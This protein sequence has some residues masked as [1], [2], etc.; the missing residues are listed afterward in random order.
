MEISIGIVAQL[1]LSF[2]QPGFLYVRLLP[3]SVDVCILSA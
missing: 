3:N 1:P 2:F